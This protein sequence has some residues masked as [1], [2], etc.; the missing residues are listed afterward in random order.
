M[1]DMFQG[2][3]RNMQSGALACLGLLDNI[4]S[5]VLPILPY[6]IAWICMNHISSTWP[7]NKH[8]ITWPVNQKTHVI[9]CYQACDS[10]SKPLQISSFDFQR[11]SLVHPP[12]NEIRWDVRI[13]SINW[14]YIISEQLR[15]LPIFCQ[16]LWKMEFTTIAIKCVMNRMAA[17]M[18]VLVLKRQSSSCTRF[19]ILSQ[20]GNP[21]TEDSGV[22]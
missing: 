10:A 8:V 21:K 17:T 9:S 14:V 5:D 3:S 15:T 19:N 22:Y 18:A 20:N 11:M 12:D 2:K 4:A 1:R 7:G 6:H 13:L 16:H